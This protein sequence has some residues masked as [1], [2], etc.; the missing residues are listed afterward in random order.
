M[1]SQER[2][3]ILKLRDLCFERYQQ[4]G[5]TKLLAKIRE[6]NQYDDINGY[7]VLV[8]NELSCAYDPDKVLDEL[9][10]ASKAQTFG[11]PFESR[12]EGTQQG[13]AFGLNP[14]TDWALAQLKSTPTHWHIFVAADYYSIGD[15]D[16]ESW[17]ELIENPFAHT[18]RYWENLW[19]WIM[20]YYNVEKHP[21]EQRGWN[22]KATVSSASQFIASGQHGFIFHNRIPYLR[23]PSVK[24]T[25]KH[26]LDGEWKGHVREQSKDDLLCLWSILEGKKTIYCTN[27]DVKD[28]ICDDG[29]GADDVVCFSAHPSYGTF[30]PYYLLPR[31]IT[32]PRG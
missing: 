11:S 24:S 7:N 32:F 15:L 14:Y 26:W 19:C 29:V 31:G 30:R 10:A 23:P 3:K 25:D 27:P 5:L 21:A 6:R 22:A 9:A 4:F 8:N 1:L 28:D 16:P 17:F 12:L 18:D 2:T 20:S 13:I